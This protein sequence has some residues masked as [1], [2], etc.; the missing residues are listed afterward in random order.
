MV[1]ILEI[2]AFITSIL[3][4]RIGDIFGRR[5]TLL[6][7]A[8]IFS[9]GGVIQTFALGFS[10]M[11]FGRIVSGFGVGFLSYVRPLICDRVIKE[12][13]QDRNTG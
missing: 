13:E 5:R 1:S 4:G 3:A 2:G 12:A 7:G 8:I 6:W 10:M 9:I 11:V